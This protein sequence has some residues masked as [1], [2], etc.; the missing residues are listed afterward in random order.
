MTF[1]SVTQTQIDHGLF[2]VN[3]LEQ[4]GLSVWW[5]NDVI[6]PGQTWDEVVEE[7]ISTALCVIV[8]WSGLSVNSEWVKVEAAE[9]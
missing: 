8:V 4:A 9:A 1:S 2:A 5:N 3:A 6:P 7:R